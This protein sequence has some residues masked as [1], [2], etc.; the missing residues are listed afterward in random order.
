MERGG[1]EAG[2]EK[3][4]IGVGGWLGALGL[5]LEGRVFE[6]SSGNKGK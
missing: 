3:A 2:S 6:M 4:Q 1:G 5:P